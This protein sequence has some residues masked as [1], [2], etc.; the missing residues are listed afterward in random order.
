MLSARPDRTIVS[1]SCWAVLAL[2]LGACGPSSHPTVTQPSPIGDGS[3]PAVA[4]RV[5]VDSRSSAV[6]IAGVSPVAVEASSAGDKLQFALQLGDGETVASAVAT[7]V[8]QQA[9]DFQVTATVTNAANQTRVATAPVKVR[10]LEGRWFQ[11]GFNDRTRQFEVRRIAI[12]EQRGPDVTGTFS[13]YGELDR[14]FVGRVTP[15]RRLEITLAD[16]S[17]TF[18]GTVPDAV[19]ADGATLSMT[20][21]GG[22]A[23]GKTLAFTPVIGT[24]SGPPPQAALDLRTDY[25]NLPYTIMGL[26]PI[27]FDASGSLGD[28]LSYFIE[29]GDGATTSQAKTV[30]AVLLDGWLTARATTVDKYGR[31][32]SVSRSFLV[33]PLTQL[34][35]PCCETWYNIVLNAGKTEQRNLRFT[36]HIG[37]HVAGFY[38][39]PTNNGWET[40]FTGSV[41]G[42]QDLHL[43]LD[44][45]TIE[46][47]GTISSDV[48]RRGTNYCSYTFLTLALRGGSADG[49]VLPFDLYYSEC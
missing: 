36:S 42:A 44:D 27:T 46:L 6:A 12:S 32:D 15:D 30:Q 9:G 45:G 22:T 25:H 21:R 13:V 43:R 35:I 29:L 11:A 7:H 23:D 34:E 48:T 16:G 26:T 28:S 38:A 49:L 4:L 47:S 19:I 40:R 3:A 8:Y 2:A 14:P 41:G 17:A 37:H 1:K 5:T 18:S 39:H 20:A 33:R 24:P 31:L 10:S